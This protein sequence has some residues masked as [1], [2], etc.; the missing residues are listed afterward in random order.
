M[1]SPA[2]HAP[3]PAPVDPACV[4][5]ADDR[6]PRTGQPEVDAA[7]AAMIGLGSLPLREHHERL[8]R[9][10]ETLHAHLQD[11]P[12]GESRGLTG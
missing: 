2:E 1:S 12:R 6:P 11:Q 9:A 4:D 5:G 3:V 7:L 8:T 10:H